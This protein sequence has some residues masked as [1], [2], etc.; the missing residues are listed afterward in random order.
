V[1][2]AGATRPTN[3]GF[4][5]A[6]QGAGFTGNGQWSERIGSAT[7]VAKSFQ[8]GG[9]GSLNTGNSAPGGFGGGGGGGDYQQGV[10]AG[11]GGYGGGGSGGSASAGAGGGGGGSYDITNAYSGSA[12]NSATGYVT[13]TKL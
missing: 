3:L 11:G 2:P 4:S 1:G 5:W 12:T 9:T 7:N 6:D 8:N 13:I 10:G